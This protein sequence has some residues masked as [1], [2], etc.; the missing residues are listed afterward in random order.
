MVVCTTAG[1]ACTVGCALIIGI[2][3]KP[4]IYVGRLYNRLSANALT[5]Y[6]VTGHVLPTVVHTRLLAFRLPADAIFWGT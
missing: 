1:G 6:T 2:R 5:F 3:R 4:F